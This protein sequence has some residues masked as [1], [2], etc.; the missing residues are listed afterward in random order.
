MKKFTILITLF[1]VA[2]GYSQPTT[3]APVPTRLQANVIS[4]YS[5]SFTA[6]GANFNPDW[7]Q[8]GFASANLAY[9]PT[10]SGTNTC[11]AYTNL[12]YQGNQFAAPINLVGTGMEK[13]HIDIWTP[14]CTAFDVFL[15]ASGPIEQSVTL[16]PTLSG[17]NSFDIPLTSFS[18]VPQT[19]VI[20]FKYVGTP[21]GTSTVY[22]DN[23]YFWKSP[24]VLTAP[25]TNAPVPTRLQ[26]NVVS[27]YSDSY[28]SIASNFNPGWGQTGAV[29]TT[30]LPTGSGTNNVLAYTNFN[31]QGTDVTT[32]D[33]SGMEYLHV[34]VW[35]NANPATTILQVSP[36]NGGAGATGPVEVLV[37]IPHTQGAWYSIDIPK[38]SFTGM[39]WNA[40]HQLKFAA[41]G[42]GSTTPADFY[43]DNV[44]FWKVPASTTQPTTN[45]PVPTRLQAD[46]ISVYSNS[47]TNIAT[48]YNPNWG[49]SGFGT[50]SSTF[51]PTT[52]GSNTCL[53]YTN[54]NYQGT[55]VT[56]TNAS[57]MEFLHVD[58]W[59]N[60]NPATTILQ[61]SP[62]NGG[63]GATGAVEVLV[64]I[65]HTQGNWY[66]VDIPKST[67]T[68]MTWNAIHQLKFAANGAGS[69]VPANFYID[70]VYFWKTP[71]PAGTPTYGAF[72]I[73]AKTTA[74]PDFTIT[75]PTSTSPAPITYSSGNTAVATIVGGNMIHIVGPGTSVITANQVAQ[76]A[77]LAGSTTAT[78]VV[79]EVP[80]VAAPTP[81][82]RAPGNVISLFSDVYT[83]IIVDNWN[84]AP[85][86]YAPTGKPVL[87][88]MV[89]TNPTKK[90]EFA[91]DGFI[92]VVLNARN[93][94]SAMTHFHMDYWVPSSANLV[95]K[96]L[97]PKWSN[98]PGTGGENNA[99]LLTNLP[100]TAGSWVS[101]DVPLSSFTA[102]GTVPSLN[103]EALK[104][105]LITSNL[106]DVYVDNI[107]LHNNNLS[108]E[109]F[110]ASNISMYP[111]PATN[112]L[113]IE[114]LND[115]EKV[116]VYNILGQE[117]IS[118]N[119]N[120]K[121]VN[122][123]ISSINKGIYIIKTT[124]DGVVSAS[125]F[126]K[127]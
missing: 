105:F 73:P 2:I 29:N 115:I 77:F 33:L 109:S 4:V 64:T 69:T 53:A 92:G 76:G 36:I 117:V 78:F 12:N 37:T 27:V 96:V 65:A 55:D 28:T 31:Y 59:S 26:A 24:V 14:N 42:A 84:Q 111:N 110:S 32:T 118:K 60:A 7:G 102:Q 49:Q 116:S 74:D 9:N 45:A 86:W 3:N 122:L 124:I 101:L 75:A 71:T 82:F 43:I 90:I 48:N 13:L 23:I 34:D 8:S 70:N 5:D 108:T 97:N 114:A 25:N 88:V 62:I 44:Y 98:H 119:V 85:I 100:T 81:P 11:L 35:S 6:S 104:E 54:F 94:A 57:T 39:T 80:T 52:T 63:A 72:T 112:L 15:I 107:Y 113:N 19:G 58:V 18:S 91:G 1:A 89:A 99:L 67:F 51:L 68:G 123:D 10:G 21:F 41:N 103:R 46:V 30:F 120:N 127:E 38:S 50:T 20:Q 83:N 16:T 22:L 95:G 17:W 126:V 93:D 121:V 56:T 79:S 106:G 66:S 125:R 87:D 61:V 40:V 47:Y